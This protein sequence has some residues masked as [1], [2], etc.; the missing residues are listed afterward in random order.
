M[1]EN[2]IFELKLITNN[3]EEDND[4]INSSSEV[5]KAKCI[6]ETSHLEFKPK[7]KLIC[8]PTFGANKFLCFIT[9]IGDVYLKGELGKYNFK[10]F[11][12]IENISNIKFAGCGEDFI[13]LIDNENNFFGCGTDYGQSGLHKYNSNFYKILE[14]KKF[15]VD[16]KDKIKFI[17]CSTEIVIIVTMENKILCVGNLE[18]L[19]GEYEHI[20]EFKYLENNL[21]EIKDLQCGD[22]H[23]IILDYNG[24]V[25]GAGS[26]RDGQLGFEDFTIKLNTF[27]KLNVD[28][29]VKKI[30]TAPDVTF[31]LNYFNEIYSCGH[32]FLHFGKKPISENTGE[33]NAV[34]VVGSDFKIRKNPKCLFDGE[35]EKKLYCQTF[36]FNPFMDIDIKMMGD[37]ENCKRD[38]DIIKKRNINNDNTKDCWL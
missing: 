14:F 17:R 1:S 10:E 3:E 6:L 28:F 26:N 36:N 37:E 31:L 25:Y 7:I 5:F 32:D 18:T 23:S 19:F 21:Q 29:K 12:K 30:M 8:S 11:T 4:D 15:N 33:D 24:N 27:Q 9:E 2:E 20:D 16:I 22:Y 13:L 34:I 38:Y 35:F